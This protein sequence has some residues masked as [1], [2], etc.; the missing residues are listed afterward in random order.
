VESLDHAH[1]TF[2]LV[3]SLA[4]MACAN[5]G[6]APSSGN[7]SSRTSAGDASTPPATPP[8]MDCGNMGNPCCDGR[9]EGDLRC[10]EDDTCGRAACGAAGEPCCDET[11]QCFVGLTCTVDGC[12]MTG[13]TTPPCGGLGQ[14]CCAGSAPCGTGLSCEA[15]SC[16]DVTTSGDAGTPPPPPADSGAPPPPPPTGDPC[17]DAVDCLDCTSRS[18]CGFCDGVCMESDILGPPGCLD[19]AWFT[20]ECVL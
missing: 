5:G 2:I 19:Y 6:P 11:P 1:R 17:A 10:L 4:L 16:S 14:A 13:G 7:S 3:G 18:T 12:Q 8:P 15:G 9:C 20:F